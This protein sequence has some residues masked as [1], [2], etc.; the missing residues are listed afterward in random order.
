MAIST[1]P[2]KI[3][4]KAPSSISISR[5]NPAGPVTL[6]ITDATGTLKT[7]YELKNADAGINRLLWDMQFDP[8]PA[9][10]EG[11]HHPDAADDGA[12]FGETRG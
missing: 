3:P 6:E 5:K 9:S 7:L 8:S 4:R 1:L 12:H 11:A 2:E 10:D